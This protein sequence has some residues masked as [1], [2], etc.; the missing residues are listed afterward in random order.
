MFE[1]VDICCLIKAAT[2]YKVIMLFYKNST[3]FC[4]RIYLQQI[5]VPRSIFTIFQ[6]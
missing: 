3:V 4:S 5:L 6:V 1:T 2:F